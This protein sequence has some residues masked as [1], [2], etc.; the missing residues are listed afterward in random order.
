MDGKVARVAETEP[1]GEGIKIVSRA[2]LHRRS[3]KPFHRPH[4]IIV[5][6][7][8]NLCPRAQTCGFITLRVWIEVY[9]SK[10]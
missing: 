6:A 10:P 1:G 7:R 3:L 9:S 5:F 2:Q 4:A 8:E